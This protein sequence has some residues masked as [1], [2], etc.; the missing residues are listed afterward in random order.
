MWPFKAHFKIKHAY[1]VIVLFTCSVMSN[2]FPTLQFKS[3]TSLALSLLYGPT[4]TFIHDY[5]KKTIALTTWTF[6]GKV[7]SLFFNMLCSFVIAFLPRSKHLNFMAAVTIHSDTGAQENE[8][9]YCFYFLIKIKINQNYFYSY[10]L[11][12]Q[13]KYFLLTVI[14][15]KHKAYIGSILV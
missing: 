12:W 10:I 1:P 7:I 6:V 15:Y 4:L 2:S 3:I 9:Y 8:I 14:F 13:F 11:E 5:W